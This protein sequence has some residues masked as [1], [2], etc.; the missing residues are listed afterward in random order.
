M[1]LED[2]QNSDES[3]RFNLN[4]NSIISER[5]LT[6]SNLIHICISDQEND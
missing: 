1:R 3:S 4:C 2:Y 6:S 5:A